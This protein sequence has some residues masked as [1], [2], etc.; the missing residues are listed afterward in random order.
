[1]SGLILVEGGRLA[2]LDALRST[3]LLSCLIGL[4]QGS[5]D[6]NG[7]LPLSQIQVATFS[8]YSGLHALP[9]WSAAVLLGGIAVSYATPRLWQHDG[10]PQQCYVSGYYVVD[11]SGSVLLWAAYL[12][13]P[14]PMFELGN[15]VEVT[16]AYAV[17]SRY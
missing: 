1:M 5:P 10:G 13:V 9:G 8:G 3:W 15:A 7:T 6:I 2:T 12:P 14:V 11:S 16:P 4:F 17:G